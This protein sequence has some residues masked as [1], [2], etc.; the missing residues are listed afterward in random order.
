MKYKLGESKDFNG[1]KLFRVVALKDFSNVKKGDVGGWIKKEEN[2]SQNGNCW[3]FNN[4][5]VYSNARVSGNAQVYGDAQVY[6]D[7]QVSG[8]AQI[9]GEAWV[10][11]DARVFNN[12]QV[13]SDAKVSGGAW[14][15][16]N[17][18]VYSDAQV[19]GNAQIF[20][21]A[22]IFGNVQVSGGKW[23]KAPLMIYGSQHVICHSSPRKITIGCIS[24]TFDKWLK[25]YIEVG[26]KNGY[27]ESEIK[28]YKRYIDF[29]IS[30]VTK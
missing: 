14:V 9:S 6:S 11:G 26:K 2:L 4:A 13:Y 3:V 20:G 23:I 28:E 18:R 21:N 29:I 12:A 19:Y 15:Y 25:D 16:S 22:R 7:A 1:I 30:S 17:A 24:K 10:F 8:N 5:R 27:S